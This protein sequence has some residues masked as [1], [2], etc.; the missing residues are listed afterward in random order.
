M[1]PEVLSQVLRQLP[2][3]HSSNLLVGIDTSDDA[4]VYRLSP[5]LATIQ[6]VDFFTPMVDDPYLFGQIAAANAISDVYA[7]GGVPLLALNIVCFPSCLP[8]EILGEILRGGADKVIEAG[9]VVA[10]GHSV[11]DD[12]PKYGLSVTGVV[13]P[14]KIYSNATASAG[15]L[16][17]LTKPL[18][19]GIINTGIKA[20]MVGQEVM[21]KAILTMAALNKEAALAMQ[22]M[23]AS[24][25]TDI[26]GFGFLGHAA[27]MCKGS[28]VS[29]TVYANDVPIL[30]GAKE[31]AKMGI[32]PAGA[33]NNRNHLGDAVL[34]E[35]GVTR[36]DVDIFFDPQTSGG[37]LIA[38]NPNKAKALLDAIHQRGVTEARIVGELN[39]PGNH[40]ITVKRGR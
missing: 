38:V 22:D 23:G 6:T 34:V 30:P 17:I 15:D 9:A 28:G 35:E 25:C 5:E 8:P 24:A 33:Y 31:L 13:H 18:G 4:A 11:Q 29:L 1:G 27:E 16:L 19:T 36:E 14:D 39:K 3:T 40:L 10:G 20:D 37:L 2:K 7:M 21:D 32:I 26:T 12:E